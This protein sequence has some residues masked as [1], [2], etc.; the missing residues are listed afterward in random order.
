M[1]IDPDR[2]RGREDLLPIGYYQLRI[3]GVE[4]ATSRAGNR[5]AVVTLRVLEE[6]H[7]GAE[8]TDYVVFTEK[9][10]FRVEDY[11]KAAGV[12]AFDLDESDPAEQLAGLLLGKVVKGKVI[13]DTYLSDGETRTGAKVRGV[14]PVQQERDPAPGT[15]PAMAADHPSQDPLAPDTT[16]LRPV[17]DD[18]V[19]F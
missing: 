11:A 19:P 7:K 17:P 6:P 15:H 14:Y 16:G 4:P 5:M 10:R 8:L 2:D 1:R 12:P 13:H 18:D 9:A 3:A